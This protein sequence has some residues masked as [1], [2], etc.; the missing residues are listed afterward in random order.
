MWSLGDV[1]CSLKLW[2]SDGAPVGAVR[3]RIGVSYRSIVDTLGFLGLTEMP[4]LT[5]QPSI[6]TNDELLMVQPDPR[7]PVKRDRNCLLMNLHLRIG[8]GGG[9]VLT[10]NDRLDISMV[11]NSPSTILLY[12]YECLAPNIF[13][14]GSVSGKLKPLPSVRAADAAFIDT[15]IEGRYVPYPKIPDAPGKSMEEIETLGRRLFPFTP[16]SFQLAMCVYDWTTASFTRKP[17]PQRWF[18]ALR[19][20]PRMLCITRT[21][22]CWWQT[23]Q[24]T[25]GYGSRQHT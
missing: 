2:F 8:N 15:M 18:G 25:R 5:R 16:F 24:E 1:D 23:C 13:P 7:D 12:A 11:V 10:L 4:Y 9:F 20:M 14:A 19:T 3:P 6:I 21:E 17:S 22:S